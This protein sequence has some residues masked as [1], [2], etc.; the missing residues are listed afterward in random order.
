MYE[1]LKNKLNKHLNNFKRLLGINPK[2]KWANY[3]TKTPKEIKY[4]NGSLI[5]AVLLSASMYPNNI[6]IEYYNTQISYVEFVNKI[7]KCARSLK[8]IGVE[9]DDRVTICM[10]NTPEAVIMFY[11]INMVGAV[12]NMIH[13]LSSEN[14]INFYLNKAK[15]KVILTIDLCYP[16]VMNAIKDTKVKHVVVSSATKSMGF[17]VDTF[18]YLFKGRKNDKSMKK[19]KEIVLSWRQFIKN[20]TYYNEEYY[21]KRKDTDLAVILYSGGTTGKPKGICLSNLNFNAGAVQSRYMSDT[22]K[23]SNSFLT[24][25][26]NFHAFGIGISTHTPLY[27]GMKVILIPKFDMKKMK[28]ILK[29]YHPNVIAGVPSLFDAITKLKLGPNDLSNL[30]LAVCGGDSITIENKKKINEYFKAHG[31]KTDLRVGYGLTEGAGACCLSPEG[32]EKKKDIIGIPFP[33]CVYKI[34]DVND[35]HEVNPGEDGEIL[36]SGPNVML[37]Y[38]DEPKE[39]KETLIKDENGITWLHTGDMGS[40]DNKG[41][42]YYRSRIKR[43]IITNGYNVYPSYIEELLAKNEYVFQCAVIGIK[44]PYKGEVAKAFI[45]LKEGIKPSLEIKRTINKYLKQNLANYA[46]PQE[47]EYVDGLPMTL[48]GKISYKDLH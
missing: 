2:N 17:V 38:L 4:D 16:K 7:K 30:T 15:S 18:Y 3:Y 1:S 42:I 10:P 28:K 47:I 26:P 32:M 22:M 45:V 25:L 41:L 44:H 11:A 24:I 21:V 13:P 14:E 40:M 37:G 9:E 8:R 39:T 20:G 48:V 29:K 6:A 36:I 43:M 23:P 34:V 27:S 12:A 19:N 33:N 35:G 31:C 46:I 5:D